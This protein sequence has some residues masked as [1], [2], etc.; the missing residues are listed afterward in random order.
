MPSDDKEANWELK[1]YIKTQSSF[2]S[3]IFDAA[4]LSFS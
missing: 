3:L 1:Q 4:L 2:S